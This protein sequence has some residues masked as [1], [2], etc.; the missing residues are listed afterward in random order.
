MMLVRCHH[1][2][3]WEPVQVVTHVDHRQ[4]IVAIVAMVVM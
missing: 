3:H 1:C 2:D 4:L